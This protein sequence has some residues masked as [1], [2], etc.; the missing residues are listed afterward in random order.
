MPAAPRADALTAYSGPMVRDTQTTLLCL[1]TQLEL[2]RL[3]A[4]APAAVD[5]ERWGAV[6]VIGFGP[7]AAAA[8]VSR[9]LHEHAP[10]HIVL[11][12][13]AGSYGPA[14]EIGTAMTFGSIAMDGVGAGEGAAFVGPSTMG[15]PQWEG[16][17]NHGAVVD[18]LTLADDG[19]QLLTV[20]AAAE[21]KAMLAARRRR[22]PDAA[23]ED[24]EGFGVALAAAMGTGIG[25]VPVSIYRGI[26][27]VAGNRDP[28]MWKIDDALAAVAESLLG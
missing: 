24:M 17:T 5:P 19:P 8:S 27:N 11:A 12:G 15:F 1:P 4:L 7:V 10:T 2:L 18:R 13:I 22:F 3:T 6:A 16:N 26:S 23:A 21:G 20:A 9:L 14:S 25:A 28:K